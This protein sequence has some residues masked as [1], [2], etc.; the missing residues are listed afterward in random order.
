MPN[1]RSADLA[2]AKAANPNPSGCIYVTLICDSEEELTSLTI[3]L[4]DS[5]TKPGYRLG[6]AHTQYAPNPKL[7][8]E[9]RVEEKIEAHGGVSL[10]FE[11]HLVDFDPNAPIT[12]PLRQR[13]IFMQPPHDEICNILARRS[14]RRDIAIY[15]LID[16]KPDGTILKAAIA[17]SVPLHTLSNYTPSGP[18]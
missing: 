1:L 10:N 13:S 6:Y 12:L 9:I 17:D 16:H 8:A 15:A 11:A 5:P 2:A 4:W 18:F 7:V 14:G 3:G